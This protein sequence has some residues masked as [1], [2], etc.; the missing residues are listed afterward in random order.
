MKRGKKR[1]SC[2]CSGGTSPTTATSL[3]LDWSAEDVPGCGGVGKRNDGERVRLSPVFLTTA[4][5]SCDAL[6][7]GTTTTTS[8]RYIPCPP[9]KL[10]SPEELPPVQHLRDSQGTGSAPR[11]IKGPLP[12]G[13][14]L[15]WR[16]RWASRFRR[17][18]PP[19]SPSSAS[20]P[21]AAASP[22]SSTRPRYGIDL[23]SYRP[24]PSPY[25]FDERK[26]FFFLR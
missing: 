24:F 25:S 17:C 11:K 4:R 10:R 12:S 6:H 8:E 26:H 5:K 13:W 9:D 14:S 21:S 20:S 22:R 7:R 1:G 19:S 23:H 15:L 16:S 18:S 2:I 3:V